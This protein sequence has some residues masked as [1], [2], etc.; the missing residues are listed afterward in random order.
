MRV[1]KCDRCKEVQEDSKPSEVVSISNGDEF[2][3][4]V[5]CERSFRSWIFTPPPKVAPPTLTPL[6]DDLPF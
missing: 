4:C 5:D 6:D 1:Y 2:E 3:L